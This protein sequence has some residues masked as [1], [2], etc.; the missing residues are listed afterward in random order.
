MAGLVLGADQVIHLELL[1]A[2]FIAQS[3]WRL[4]HWFYFD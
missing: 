2:E 4:Q 3:P 1:A